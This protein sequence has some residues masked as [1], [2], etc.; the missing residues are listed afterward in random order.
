MSP[1]LPPTLIKL[2][3]SGDGP[4]ARKALSTLY[5]TYQAPVRAYIFRW[6]HGA[7]FKA[8][9]VD[10]L[11]QEFFSLRIEKLDLV[12]N[13]DPE[14]TRFRT[15]LFAALNYFLL[16]HL[17][18]E[19]RARLHVCYDDGVHAPAEARTPERLV[20][21]AWARDWARSLIDHASAALRAEYERKGR[22]ELHDGL[23]PYLGLA[24]NRTEEPPYA[25]LS[26]RLGK[27]VVAL[28]G[29]MFKMRSFWKAAVWELARQTVPEDEVQS[30]LQLL[31]SVLDER[32]EALPGPPAR[33]RA[34]A[35]LR[36]G[37]A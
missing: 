30:E 13:W 33:R 1:T 24:A 20:A 28:R 19:A 15:W 18:R 16:N 23:R 31:I 11:M 32:D 37:A 4:S 34:A 25:E 36:E 5:E 27:S 3:L 14:R 35:P 22:S 26:K 6:R 21:D 7:A 8:E 29:D 2:A 9:Q 17:G 12:R 10:D